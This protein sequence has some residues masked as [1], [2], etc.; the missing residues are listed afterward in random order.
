MV[1][2]TLFPGVALFLPFGGN[3]TP[4]RP[5]NS[6]IIRIVDRPNVYRLD[7]AFRRLAAH[8]RNTRQIGRFSSVNRR[9]AGSS[10]AR[11]AN[12]PTMSATGTEQSNSLRSRMPLH[13]KSGLEGAEHC[14]A[15]GAVMLLRMIDDKDGTQRKPCHRDD[16]Q[17]LASHIV[18]DGES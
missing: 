4:L 9:V 6:R 5:A 17:M 18:L 11:G 10:P 7:L 13:R 2:I 15:C 3:E 1:R 8:L 14:A 12:F 16:R